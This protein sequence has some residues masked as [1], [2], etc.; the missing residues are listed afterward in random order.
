MN[1]TEQT[2]QDVKLKKLVQGKKPLQEFID[3]F[4]TTFIRSSYFVKK[5]REELKLFLT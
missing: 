3:E 2:E 5:D 1:P 4:E